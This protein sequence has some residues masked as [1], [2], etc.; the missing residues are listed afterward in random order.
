MACGSLKTLMLI[1]M[2]W[3]SLNYLCS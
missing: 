3:C 2:P 1:I